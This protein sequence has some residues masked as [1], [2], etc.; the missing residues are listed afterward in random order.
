MYHDWDQDQD[1]EQHANLAR[2]LNMPPSLI[3]C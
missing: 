3:T 2:Q 1:Q